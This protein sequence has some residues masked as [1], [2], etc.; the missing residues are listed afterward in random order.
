MKFTDEQYKRLVAIVAEAY[1]RR[2]K[3]KEAKK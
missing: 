3:K 2:K 1:L